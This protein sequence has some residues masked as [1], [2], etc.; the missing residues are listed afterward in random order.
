MNDRMRVKIHVEI[1]QEKSGYSTHEALRY[2]QEFDINATGFAGVAKIL[3]NF[4][5]AVGT[6]ERYKPLDSP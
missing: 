2:E 5:K 3:G 4:D 6:I 1:S